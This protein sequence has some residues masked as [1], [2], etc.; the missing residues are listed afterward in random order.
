MS[1][2]HY[3]AQG[4][5]ACERPVKDTNSVEHF[6]DRCGYK[7]NKTSVIGDYISGVYTKYQNPGEPEKAGKNV[8]IYEPL[9]YRGTIND[10]KTEFIC[11]YDKYEDK[12][13]LYVPTW[14][15]DGIIE[16]KKG[17]TWDNNVNFSGRD[18]S[19][20]NR[21]IISGTYKTYIKG[22]DTYPVAK[23]VKYDAKSKEGTIDVGEPGRINIQHFSCV[24]NKI[25][26]DVL[27]TRQDGYLSGTKYTLHG[28][29]D[30]KSIYFNDGAT[31]TDKAT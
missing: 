21:D 9:M 20:C 27:R 7:T 16:N 11:K 18:T 3:T 17:I 19:I 8:L 12:T 5:L 26:T 4:L 22:N 31:Y 2:C 23:E 13:H 14:V 1:H 30:D 15:R 29:F 24:G 28:V 25:V 6:V 10:M